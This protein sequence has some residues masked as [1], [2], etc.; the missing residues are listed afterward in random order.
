LVCWPLV[1]FARA[2]SLMDRR[3]QARGVWAR[4]LFPALIASIMLAGCA[5]EREGGFESPVPGARLE[6]IESAAQD[7]RATGRLPDRSVRE[8]LVECL[9]A[10]DPLVRFMAIGTLRDIA[11]DTKGYRHDDPE[12]LRR[13]AIPAW[14]AWAK[15]PDAPAAAETLPSPQQAQP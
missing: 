10:D 2:E 9:H 15:T 13:L 7:F 11:G 5:G 3:L 4:S 14:V 1:E 8:E 12:P 6:A